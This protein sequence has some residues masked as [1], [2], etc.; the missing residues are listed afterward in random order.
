MVDE[1]SPVSQTL[2]QTGNEDI[3]VYC[4][5][6]SKHHYSSPHSGCR[7]TSNIKGTKSKNLNVSRI[8]L[9]LPVPNPLKPGVKSSMVN[10]N[11]IAY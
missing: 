7:Q 2:F 1:I 4:S 3:H 9:S 11:Y 10:K 6:D 5:V 8:L